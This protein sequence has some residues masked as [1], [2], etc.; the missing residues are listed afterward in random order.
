M[1][2]LAQTKCA[3]EWTATEVTCTMRAMDV[4]GKTLSSLPEVGWCRWADMIPEGP[5]CRLL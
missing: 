1:A 2:S 3:R 4:A 5:Q